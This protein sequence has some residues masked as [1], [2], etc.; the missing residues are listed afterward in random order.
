MFIEHLFCTGH[1]LCLGYSNKRQSLADM[2]MV[3]QSEEQENNVLLGG[4]EC[5]KIQQGRRAREPY[6]NKTQEH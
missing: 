6:E 3:G 2:G 5:Y 4:D 1:L